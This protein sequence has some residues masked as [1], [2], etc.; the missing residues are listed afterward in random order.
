MAFMHRIPG[1]AY[2]HRGQDLAKCE[3]KFDHGCLDWVEPFFRFVPCFD[4]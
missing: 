2:V 3:L 4:I 1:A